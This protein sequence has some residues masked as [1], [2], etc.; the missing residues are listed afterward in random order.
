MV[1]VVSV[2]TLDN[3]ILR[4]KLSDGRKGLYDVKPYLDLEVFQEL[5]NPRYFKRAFIDHGTVAWPHE[6]DLAPDNIEVELQPEPNPRS[7]FIPK[8]ESWTCFR[9]LFALKIADPLNQNLF[10]SS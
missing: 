10:R 9:L 7:N 1:R 3:Y 8:S 5:K 6:E 2:E 4:L